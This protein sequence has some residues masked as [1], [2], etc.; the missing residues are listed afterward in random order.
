MESVEKRQDVYKRQGLDREIEKA[1]KA[2]FCFV[3]VDG[4]FSRLNR[5]LL[6]FSAGRWDRRGYGRSGQLPAGIWF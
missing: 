2:L 3:R 4:A 5:R 6:L 1:P